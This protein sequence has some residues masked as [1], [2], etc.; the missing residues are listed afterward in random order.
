MRT[1]RH[2][3]AALLVI[4]PC[5]FASLVAVAAPSAAKLAELLPKKLDG[6]AM[7]G[8]PTLMEDTGMAAGAYLDMKSGK[9]INVNIAKVLDAGFAK[10]QFQVWGEGAPVDKGT[11]RH[12]GFTVAGLPGAV[13]GWNQS[14]GKL[15]S[16][17]EVIAGDAYIHV[18]VLPA[19]ND[20][21]AARVLQMLDVAKFAKLAGNAK[22]A[23]KAEAPKDTGS[24]W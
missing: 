16:E 13:K 20:T 24:G 5:A 17:A 22:P 23:A 7:T 18:S 12:S 3:P 11:S 14:D 21:D 4:V 1:H 6:I 19:A 9:A 8:K 2:V 10:A 15:Q